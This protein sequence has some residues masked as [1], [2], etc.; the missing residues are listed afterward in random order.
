METRLKTCLSQLLFYCCEETPV[1]KATYRRKHL[2]GAGLQF[3]RVNP[4]PSWQEYGSRQAGQAGRQA[5]MALDQYLGT[6][7]LICMQ[8]AE[9]GPGVGF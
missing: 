7:I 6:Y 9:I 8:E 3:Q 5:G 4:W 2:S 1:T